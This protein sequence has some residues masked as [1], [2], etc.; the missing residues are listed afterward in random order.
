MGK[1]TGC[2]NFKTTVWLIGYSFTVH[3][4]N[5][6]QFV[7][8]F[9]MECINIGQ[10]ICRVGG[11]GIGVRIVWGVGGGKTKKPCQ[12]GDTNGRV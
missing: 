12:Q 11:K 9:F 8:I 2:W 6:H 7:M 3:S 5:F 1:I 10:R 4:S